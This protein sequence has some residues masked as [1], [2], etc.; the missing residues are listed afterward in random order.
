MKPI[1]ALLHS[2]PY[3]PEFRKWAEPYIEFLGGVHPP[4]PS[5]INPER[6]YQQFPIREKI[7]LAKVKKEH[8]EW[9]IQNVYYG[10]SSYPSTCCK[11]KTLF[12][13]TGEDPAHC[14]DC[15][16]KIKMAETKVEEKR[17]AKE[18]AVAKLH[19]RKISPKT[20]HD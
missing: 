13:P 17:Q 1:P 14:N 4:G 11:C 20:K 6:I 8:P 12:A 5:P 18:T 7:I 16:T 9:N 3:R 2:I 10:I 15:L 19:R